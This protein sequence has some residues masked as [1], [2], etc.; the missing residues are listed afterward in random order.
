MEEEEAHAGAGAPVAGP[1]RHS[2]GRPSPQ[3]PQGTEGPGS[4]I[5]SVCP[6]A[7][8]PSLIN[9][10][11]LHAQLHTWVAQSSCCSNR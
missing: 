9:Q 2:Q 3:Q 5:Q 7:Q 6:P 10:V 1:F 4:P 11:Q 8:K